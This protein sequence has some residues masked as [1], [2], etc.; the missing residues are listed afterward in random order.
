VQSVTAG[1]TG[2]LTE[3]RLPIYCN[4]LPANLVV[5][6]EEWGPDGPDGNVLA[7]E[8]FDGASL[9]PFLTSSDV[10]LRSFAFSAPPLIRAGTQFAVV[11]D[12]TGPDATSGCAIYVTGSPNYDGTPSNLY[13]GGGYCYRSDDLIPYGYHWACFDDDY[14]FATVVD[15]VS[16]AKPPV[17]TVPSGVVADAVG[18][19]G[20]G[21]SYTASANDDVDGAVTPTCAPAA[22]SQFSIGDTTVTCTATDFSGNTGSASFVVH[23]R[24]AAE[25]MTNLSATLHGFNLAK[26]G[27]SLDDK[28]TAAQRFLAAN[29]PQQACGSLSDFSS[30]VQSQ[31]G[32]GLTVGQASYLAGSA[33]RI[34]NVI[35]C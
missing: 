11:L 35:G 10:S 31:S 9:P 7:S 8:T 24:G 34:E 12:A 5:R 21:V 32:K 14:P 1:L 20:A 28:L 16:D 4:A 27:T 15:P 29:K 2:R 22:G 18:P 6:I 3:V 26:L 25:Q 23:L 17:V 33:A 19:T 13:A 30:Q